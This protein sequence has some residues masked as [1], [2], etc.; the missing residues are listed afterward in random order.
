LGPFLDAYI[1]ARSDAKPS[2]KLVWGHTRRCL[3][4]YIGAEKPLREITPGDA[5]AWRL[6]LAEHEKLAQN[7]VN[8]RCGIAKQFFRAAFRRKLIA[9]NPFA[10]MKGCAVRGN[11]ARDHFV[12]RADAHKVLDACPDCQW[13]LLFALSRYGGLRCPS[14]HLALTWCDVNWGRG[15]ITI[16]ASKTQHHADGGIRV[17]PIFPELRPYLEAVWEQAE[18]GTKHVITRYRESKTNLRTQLQR[19]ITKAGLTPWPKL[20]QNLRATR[21]TEL[22]ETYPMHVICAWIGNSQAVAQKHYLQVTDEH[23]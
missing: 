17:V 19:I 21:E 15:R 6:W 11:K 8:R 5:D 12:S 3:V 7:T 23:F 4:E 18:P 20:W 14:E 13:Q 22:A 16:R 2:T 1:A 10:D 9:E